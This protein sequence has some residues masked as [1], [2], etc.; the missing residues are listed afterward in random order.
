MALHNPHPQRRQRGI[1]LIEL[2]VGITIGLLVVLAATGTL[3]LNRT[4]GNTISDTAALTNQANQAMRQITD[5]LRQAGAFEIVPYAPGG[6]TVLNEIQFN[7]G[8]PTSAT[9]PSVLTG[10]ND[11]GSATIKPDTV[12][13]FYQ[14]RAAAVTRDCLGNS[15]T[16][17]GT[18][19][20]STYSVASGNLQCLGVNA[21]AQP[22]AANVEDLQLQYLEVTGANSQWRTAAA[23]ANWNAVVAVNVCLQVRGDVNHGGLLTGNYVNCAGTSTAHSNNLRLVLRQTVQLRNRFNNL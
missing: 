20:Q 8:D 13:V 21:G 15:V 11:T 19:I 7:L 17:L 1:T 23:V 22:V 3:V 4:S 18:Q 5:A 2:M 16:G 10:Q 9:A 12:T 6:T 14:N